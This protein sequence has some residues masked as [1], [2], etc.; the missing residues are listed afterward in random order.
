M[1]PDPTTRQTTRQTT[2]VTR[3]AFRTVT[4]TITE[5]VTLNEAALNPNPYPN[6]RSSSTKH[7]GRSRRDPSL[8]RPFKTKQYKRVFQLPKPGEKQKGR[9]FKVSTGLPGRPRKLSP[10]TT[11]WVK[12]SQNN[13]VFYHPTDTGKR[14]RFEDAVW[15][16]FFRM[17]AK[18]P[19]S[20]CKF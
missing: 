2:R 10:G 14:V 17:Y 7:K 11:E 13:D 6:N 12:L 18:E 1:S 9:A 20:K 15:P 16:S 4:T 8:N 19:N 5:T 3:T